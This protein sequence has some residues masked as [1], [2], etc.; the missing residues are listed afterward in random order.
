MS[1]TKIWNSCLVPGTVES[2]QVITDRN[3]GRSKGYGFVEMSSD[4]EAQAAMEALDGQ[5]QGGRTIKVNE[6]KPRSESPRGG[7]RVVAVDTA[8]AVAAAVVVAINP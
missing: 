8:V 6:A 7:G 3:T 1:L 2:A 5:E 4:E